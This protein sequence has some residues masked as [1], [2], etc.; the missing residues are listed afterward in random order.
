VS[1]GRLIANFPNR[2]KKMVLAALQANGS[3]TALDYTKVE[4]HLQHDV[5][6]KMVVRNAAYDHDNLDWL[7]QAE[8]EHTKKPFRAIVSD[9]NPRSVHGVLRVSALDKEN[10][11][12]WKVNHD[13]TILREPGALAQ[14]AKSLFAISKRA[15][16]IDPNCGFENERY[17]TSLTAFLAAIRASNPA[18]ND[19][20]YHL[21][22]KADLD[23]FRQ[24]VQ[25]SIPNSTLVIPRGM[26]VHFIRWKQMPAC[27]DLHPR[28]VLTDRGGLAYEVGLD[29]GKPGEKTRIYRLSDDG[30]Y[31]IWTQ[32][33]RNP[34]DPTGRSLPAYFQFVDDFQIIGT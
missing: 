28:Y 6:A 31:E 15:K 29:A 32:Y 12:R 17:R 27:D 21:R 25:T 1:H 10:D 8:R 11:P 24:Q 4:Y 26:K 5:S 20:E 7:L 22:A 9:S 16:F 33:D 13:A 18:L 19:V 34:K 2:W 30:H 23:F 14:K 3:H